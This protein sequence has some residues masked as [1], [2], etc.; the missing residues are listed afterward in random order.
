M[1]VVILALFCLLVEKRIGKREGLLGGD[2]AWIALLKFWL[3]P[4]LSTLTRLLSLTVTG[5]L[6]AAGWKMF[7]QRDAYGESDLS[8]PTCVSRCYYFGS[9]SGVRTAV[10]LPSGWPLQQGNIIRLTHPKDCS[11][12]CKFSN[13]ALRRY[14]SQ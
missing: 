3:R 9:V 6:R 4:W 2:S 14:I 1:V 13:S 10:L 7:L 8:R 5:A 12:P 11:T